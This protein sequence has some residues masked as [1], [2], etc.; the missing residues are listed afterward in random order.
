MRRLIA[1]GA[2]AAL[3]S[4]SAASAS[5][6]TSSG[7]SRPSPGRIGIRQRTIPYSQRNNPRDRLY[8]I[9]NV[10]PGTRIQRLIQVANLSRTRVRLQVYPAAASIAHGHFMFAAGR[11]P[12]QLTTWTRVSAGGVTLAPHQLKTLKVTISVPRNASRGN[13]YGV[14]WAQD[15]ATGRSGHANV[16]LVNRVGVRMYVSV[17]PGGPPPSNFSISAPYAHRGQGGRAVVSVTA[18]NTGGSALDIQG[19]L[20]LT[21]GP[22]GLKAGP[23]GSATVATVAPGQSAPVTFLLSRSIPNGPW[24]ASVHLQSGLLV[25]NEQDSIDFAQAP[26]GSPW[27]PALSALGGVLAVVALGAGVVT[28]RRRRLIRLHA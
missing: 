2:L 4:A 1:V 19:T 12:N 23:F 3:A 7:P 16:M 14:I 28:S 10:R 22:G 24:Q 13:Q 20:K 26:G 11:T 25:R 17:G 8:I 6:A 21:G 27:L 18:K 5:A 15:A 9:Q